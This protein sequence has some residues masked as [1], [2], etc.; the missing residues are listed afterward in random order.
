[1]GNT[2]LFGDTPGTTPEV[3]HSTARL[4]VQFLYLRPR[5]TSTVEGSATITFGNPMIR[6]VGHGLALAFLAGPWS[7]KGLAERGCHVLGTKP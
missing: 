2:H 4:T 6:T 3:E 7:H 5:Q 1:M